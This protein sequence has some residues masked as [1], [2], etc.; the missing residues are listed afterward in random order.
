M[1]DSLEN[2]ANVSNWSLW[3]AS[4]DQQV[5]KILFSPPSHS[6]TFGFPPCDFRLFITSLGPHKW[7]QTSVKTSFLA[8]P[9][10]HSPIKRLHSFIILH[11]QPTLLTLYLHFDRARNRRLLQSNFVFGPKKVKILV[12]APKKITLKILRQPR[13]RCQRVQMLIM[14]GLICSVGGRDFIFITLSL[15]YIRFS[16]MRF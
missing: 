5:A 4:S 12:C 7:P 3:P 8:N 16:A 15:M 2:D 10:L 9:T 11:W 1:S 6:F 13:K 14:T